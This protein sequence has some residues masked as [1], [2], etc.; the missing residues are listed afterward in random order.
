MAGQKEMTDY[1]MSK[2]LQMWKDTS[3]PAQM[4]QLK[5]AGLNPG[6]L[7]GMGG[8]GGQSMGMANGQVSGQQTNK[9]QDPAAFAGMGIQAGLQEA[10]IE[11]MKAEARDKNAD[12]QNKE[13]VIPENIGAST[14]NLNAN[15]ALQKTQNDIAN[16]E[17][18]IKGAT[19]E[20]QIQT[21]TNKATTAMEEAMQMGVKTNTDRATQQKVID[22]VRNEYAAAIIRNV[23]MNSEIGVNEQ[24]VKQMQSEIQQKWEQVHQGWDQLDINAQNSAT[25]KFD[26]EMRSAYPSIWGVMGNS[27]QT[28]TRVVDSRKPTFTVP[29]TKNK[30]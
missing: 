11:M 15:T 19:K 14:G 3:Y 27:L 18:E 4:E 21:I 1:N 28:L 17:K 13:T 12:A 16:I 26:A 9:G 2:Q 23:L 5:K 25:Q 29:D 8:G 10:Q 6:L 22:T 30:H 7:Y 24:K 20:E